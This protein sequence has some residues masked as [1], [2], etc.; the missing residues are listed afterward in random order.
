[1]VRPEYDNVIKLDL[2]T[3]KSEIIDYIRPNRGT[4]ISKREIKM[5]V[6]KET[7]FARI[8]DVFGD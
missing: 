4:L 1:M 8:I 2:Q 7:D 5:L 3:F 6:M